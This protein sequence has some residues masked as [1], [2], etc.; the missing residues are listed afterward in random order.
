MTDHGPRDETGAT[1]VEYALMVLLVA[2]VLVV[3][4]GFLGLDVADSFRP[5]ETG[6]DGTSG[7]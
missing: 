4:V 2:A 3:V 7:G 1:A 6:I 5:V